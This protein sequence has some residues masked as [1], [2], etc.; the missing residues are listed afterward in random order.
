MVTRSLNSCYELLLAD[1]A[2]S[3]SNVELISVIL[4][5]TDKTAMLLSTDL[6]DRNDSSYILGHLLQSPTEEL[7][8]LTN[9]D[10]G[11]V[12]KLKAV[13]EIVK[14][15]TMPMS[16]DGLYQ[17]D[18][19]EDAYKYLM[20][21]I[22]LLDYERIVILL[23]NK[24]HKII[25]DKVIANGFFDDS[26]TR[27]KDILKPAITSKAAFIILAHNHP[28]GVPEPSKADLLLTQRIRT[29]CNY[30]DMPLLDSIIIGH[31]TYYSFQQAGEID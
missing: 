26:S 15:V 24:N 8:Y 20:P 19:A 13:A 9:L 22:G 7:Q 14:R 4:D 11:A 1:K 16:E 31:N 10:N 6:A 21:K 29:L 25:G 27:V 30:L 12:C 17:C 2:D 3:L 5:D 28:S 23:L 18:T